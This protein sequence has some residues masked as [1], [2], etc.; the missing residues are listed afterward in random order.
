V[1]LIIFDW[2][3]V[4]CSFFFI[5]FPSKGYSALIRSVILIQ[6]MDGEHRLWW[7]WSARTLALYFL[8]MPKMACVRCCQRHCWR[9]LCCGRLFMMKVL[10]CCDLACSSTLLEAL[11]PSSFGCTHRFFV[12]YLWQTNNT[13]AWCQI[14]AFPSSVF[15]NLD[16]LHKNQLWARPQSQH[17]WLLWYPLV[18]LLL[19]LYWTSWCILVSPCFMRWRSPEVRSWGWY[20]C[21]LLS[22]LWRSWSHDLMFPFGNEV[23]RCWA[24]PFNAMNMALS[25]AMSFPPLKILPHCISRWIV[26]GL[27]FHRTQAETVVIHLAPD[28]LR[29]EV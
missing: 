8:L 27:I 24:D 13:V 22:I 19:L 21:K 17:Q 7:R 3:C 18:V 4:A 6:T 10:D 26:W 15:F 11:M 23:Y 2:F 25:F 28:R 20:P 29:A 9:C 12:V 14:T 5:L 1:W 16:I